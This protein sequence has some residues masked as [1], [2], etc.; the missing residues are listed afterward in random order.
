M[1]Q[2][3]ASGKG[4]TLSKVCPMSMH[5]DSE[6]FKDGKNIFLERIKQ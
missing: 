1:Q 2:A 4:P 3:T 5:A 6:F